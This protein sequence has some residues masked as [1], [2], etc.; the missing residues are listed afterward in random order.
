MFTRKDFLF[1]PRTLGD[2]VK[3]RRLELQLTQGQL[4]KRLGINA[5]TLLNWETGATEPV[6][7]LIPRI[8]QFLGYDPFSPPS[9]LGQ[10]LFA[11]RRTMGWSIAVAAQ[12]LGIDESTWG[13]WERTGVIA[14]SR[15]RDRVETF[16]DCQR[17]A[18]DFGAANDSLEL[19]FRPQIAAPASAP[20]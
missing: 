11:K 7:A 20:P 15:Y 5:A 19:R 12:H 13:Q 10:R 9:T 16:L 6:I 3:K 4:A 17:A 18:D 14:W 2:H 1:D 8:L